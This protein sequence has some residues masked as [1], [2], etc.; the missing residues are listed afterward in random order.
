MIPGEEGRGVGMRG[1]VASCSTAMRCPR[2]ALGTARSP[3]L[4]RPIGLALLG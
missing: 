4:L 1:G 2:G 3:D